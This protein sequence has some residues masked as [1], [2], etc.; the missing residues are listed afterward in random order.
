M[1]VKALCVQKKEN[2]LQ[3]IREKFHATHKNT[4]D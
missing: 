2:V 3:A 1:I 4:T